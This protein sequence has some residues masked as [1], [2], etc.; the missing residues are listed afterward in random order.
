MGKLMIAAASGLIAA[1]N[2]K[3]A[4]GFGGFMLVMNVFGADYVSKY[5]M[6]S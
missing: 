1:I 5:S 2:K 6:N 3:P 4:K